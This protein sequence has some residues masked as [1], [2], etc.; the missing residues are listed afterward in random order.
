LAA[1]APRA[2]A[3]NAKLTPRPVQIPGWDSF[4]A[5]HKRVFAHMM[6]V[7][8]AALSHAHFEMGRILDAIEQ[9]GEF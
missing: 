1:S 6:E 2:F 4:D 3:Q 8:G 5:D 7:Y 9:A